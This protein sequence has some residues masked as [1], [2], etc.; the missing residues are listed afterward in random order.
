MMWYGSGPTSWV[1]WFLMMIVMVLFWG[2]IIALVVW[3]V[4]SSRWYTGRSETG[5]IRP[6]ARSILQ[7]RFARGEIDA[8]EYEERLR[9]LEGGLPKTPPQGGT[10]PHGPAS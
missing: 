5:A 1:G 6:D 7:E 4:R 3:L 8:E 2:G 9:V 10:A